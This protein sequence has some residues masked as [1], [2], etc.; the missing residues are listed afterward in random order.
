MLINNGGW[1]QYYMDEICGCLRSWAVRGLWLGKT[2][3]YL[4][5]NEEPIIIH[6]ILH[7]NFGSLQSLVLYQNYIETVEELSR[8]HLPSLT[9]LSLSKKADMKLATI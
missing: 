2:A 1:D 4:D 9:G 7:I 8:M 3:L 5:R 6:K